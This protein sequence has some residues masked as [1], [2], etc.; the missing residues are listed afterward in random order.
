MFSLHIIE[1]PQ[2][3]YSQNTLDEIV[4]GISKHILTNQN[5]LLNII[6][7]DSSGIQNLNKTYRHIDK[8]TDVLSFHYYEDF[9]GL[10]DEDIAGEL[11]FCEEKIVSQGI[12]Y[13]LGTEKEFYKL[14]IH[15]VLHIIGF[16]HEQDAEYEEMKKWED[17]IWEELFERT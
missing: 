9:S 7:L 5:G 4:E 15:S 13:G 12:E 1:K 3:S 2:F 11:I 14:V 10:R 8:A 16:D 6:F 17:I